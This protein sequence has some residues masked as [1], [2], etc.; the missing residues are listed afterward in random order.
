MKDG[1]SAFSRDAA[2]VIT[3][4]PELPMH[5]IAHSTSIYSPLQLRVNF[6]YSNWYVHQ[7]KKYHVDIKGIN[8]K[9]KISNAAPAKNKIL[10]RQKQLVEACYMS[11]DFSRPSLHNKDTFHKGSKL[12]DFVHDLP[13]Q[14]V[15]VGLPATCTNQIR[16]AQVARVSTNREKF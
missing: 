16:P 11:H 6:F 5:I 1:T 4:N 3:T 12:Q 15:P 7:G 13:E 14:M 8:T 10:L 2:A 9:S